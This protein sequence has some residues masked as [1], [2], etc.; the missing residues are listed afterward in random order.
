MNLNKEQLK[1][2]IDDVIERFNDEYTNDPEDI[3]FN[4]GGYTKEELS[5]KL[6]EKEYERLYEAIYEEF[7][8]TEDNV[9]SFVFNVLR[10]KR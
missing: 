4:Q 8:M 9:W 5:M 10:S 6:T 7:A 2:I 1:H 3:E